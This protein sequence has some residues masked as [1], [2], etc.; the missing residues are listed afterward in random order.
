MPRTSEIKRVILVVLDSVG[1]GALPDAAD[2]GD[3]GANTLLHVAEAR[4]KL[5]LPNLERM[6]LGNILTVPGVDQVKTPSASFGKMQEA[7]KGKDTVAG[8]WEIA[9]VILDQAFSLYPDGFPDEIIHAFLARTGFEGLLG[10]K[11]ASGTVI[12]EELGEAHMRTGHPIVYTSADSVFQ[13]A[14]H[15]EVIPV[16]R[17]YEICIEAR[18][19][20]DPYQIGRVIARPFTGEP[21]RF[22]RTVRRKDFSMK[23]PRKTMLDLLEAKGLP[24]TGV[25]KIE[26]IFAGQGV[27]K[28]VKTSDN[29]HGMECLLAELAETTRGLIFANLIDFDMLYGHRNDAEGYAKTLEAFDEKLPALLDRLEEDDALILTAD[30]GCDPTWPGTDHTR[31]HTPLLVFSK[32]IAPHDLGVRKTF[33][34]IAAT[35]LSWFGIES[36]TDGENLFD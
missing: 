19:I 14:A 17:L 16:D 28:S 12:I 21:G 8:H 23:P 6:G 32:R 20:C 5:G 24:V 13:I 18:T 27:T 11:S 25:G 31:E 36:K 1:V 3:A 30:H 10:N 15:E 9:G 2:Y 7:S 34:D 22:T 35:I 4:G 33:A 26:N 29:A